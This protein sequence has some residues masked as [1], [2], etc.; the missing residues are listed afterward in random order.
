[1]YFANSLLDQ[2]RK[3]VVI[4]SNVRQVRELKD[5][6]QRKPFIILAVTQAVGVLPLPYCNKTSVLSIP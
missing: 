6:S 1:M 2:P 3:M 5:T 4:S